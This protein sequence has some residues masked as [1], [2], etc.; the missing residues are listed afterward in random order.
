M[1]SAVPNP[2]PEHMFNILWA[3]AAQSTETQLRIKERERPVKWKFVWASEKD[4]NR[5]IKQW[6]K[7]RQAEGEEE[8]LRQSLSEA[9]MLHAGEILSGWKLPSCFGR[10]FA[11]IWVLV[12]FFAS[13]YTSADRGWECGWTWGS[14]LACDFCILP[15]EDASNN[16]DP[17]C[18]IVVVCRAPLLLWSTNV[19]VCDGSL[20]RPLRLLTLLIFVS[21]DTQGKDLHI[22]MVIFLSHACLFIKTHK[23]FLTVIADWI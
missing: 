18:G 17:D 14:I 9:V 13:G 19:K 8:K 10:G 11:P 6:I 15:Y 16:T 22:Q 23:M 7:Q 1:K 5:A 20:Q 2:H 4:R 12:E 3:R 21:V